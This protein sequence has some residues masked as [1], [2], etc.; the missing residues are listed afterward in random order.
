MKEG[1]AD[2]KESATNLLPDSEHFLSQLAYRTCYAISYGIV[3]PSVLVG[4]VD[5]AEQRA[6]SRPDQRAHAARD[7]VEEMKIKKGRGGD[8]EASRL[9][10]PHLTPAFR[11]GRMPGIASDTNRSGKL[12]PPNLSSYTAL[13]RLRPIITEVLRARGQGLPT[14]PIPVWTTSRRGPIAPAIGPASSIQGRGAVPST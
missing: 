2:A 8:P 12:S 13:E 14:L 1:A 6:G 3:F 11:Q 5:P 4:T 7:M 9:D 10:C